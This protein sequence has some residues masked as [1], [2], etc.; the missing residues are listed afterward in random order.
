MDSEGIDEAS[1]GSAT[2][3][4]GGYDRASGWV[5]FETVLF[6]TGSLHGPDEVPRG[7]QCFPG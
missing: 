2:C 4:T 1:V 3:V 6:S 5:V 7:S